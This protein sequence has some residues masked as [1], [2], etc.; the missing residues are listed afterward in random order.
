MINW[1]AL[2]ILIL[3]FENFFREPSKKYAEPLCST[4]PGLKNTDLINCWL[5]DSRSD[6]VTRFNALS[7]FLVRRGDDTVMFYHNLF[8]DWLVMRRESEP[9]KFLCDPRYGHLAIALSLCRQVN[10]Y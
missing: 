9:D 8:R 6:F 3:T 4:E 5:N 1:L 2:N 10:K 7:G